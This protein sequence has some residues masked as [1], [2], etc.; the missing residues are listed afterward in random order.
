MLAFSRSVSHRRWRRASHPGR[1]SRGPYASRSTTGRARVISPL[2]LVVPSRH[3]LLD[4]DGNGLQQSRE[5]GA[6]ASP[7]LESRGAT[8][9]TRS[10]SPARRIISS[11][12]PHDWVRAVVCNEIVREQVYPGIDNGRAPRRR[13]GAGLRLRVAPGANP[14]ESGRGSRASLRLRIAETGDLLLTTAAGDVRI[15][16]PSCTRRRGYSAQ[17]AARFRLSRGRHPRRRCR[18][19][20]HL[21]C[22]RRSIRPSC[23]RPRFRGQLPGQSES[24]RRRLCLGRRTRR[25]GNGYITGGPTSTASSFPAPS[26]AA[27]ESVRC[28][29]PR[30]TCREP[31]SNHA[32]RR[33]FAEFLLDLKRHCRGWQ[34]GR[35]RRRHHQRFSFPG[36]S[37]NRQRTGSGFRAQAGSVR[38]EHRSDSLPDILVVIRDGLAVD[39]QGRAVIAAETDSFGLVPPIVNALQPA[40]AGGIDRLRGKVERGRLRPSCL[41]LTSVGD[42]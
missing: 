40:K 41:P 38:L 1:A 24:G 2:S 34:W 15:A 8:G 33:A 32:H 26:G 16:V 7:R 20:N 31:W 30:S 39:A 35:V 21:R 23:A 27:G 10:G 5:C 12:I 4:G 19:G 25:N 42:G 28:W 14:S 37:G 6:D 3:G 18:P 13:R 9:G 11:V 17:I 36:H 29:C 22:P